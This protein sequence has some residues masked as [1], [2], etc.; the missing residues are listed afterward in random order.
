LADT[1]EQLQEQTRRDTARHEAWRGEIRLAASRVTGAEERLQANRRNLEALTEE[2]DRLD[3]RQPPE[4]PPGT[5]DDHEAQIGAAREQLA[6]LEAELGASAATAAA[7]AR[8]LER[9]QEQE[10]RHADSEAR[11]SERRAALEQQLATTRKRLAQLNGSTA[12]QAPAAGEEPA[13]FEK[14]LQE[15]QERHEALLNRINAAQQEHA[16]AAADLRSSHETAR[17]LQAAAEARSGYAQGPRLALTSGLPGIIGPVADLL[18]VPERYRQAAAAALGARA[19]NIVVETA[20]DGQALITWIRKK[21]AFITV[22]P[23]DLTG[24][25]RSQVP[26]RFRSRPGVIGPVTEQL[27]FAD[28][29]APLFR[30]LLGGTLLLEN[31]DAAVSLAREEPS[32]PR[33]VTLAGEVLDPGGAMSGGR[34][35]T[36][37]ALLGQAQEL[38]QLQE[39]RAEA[40]QRAEQTK[41]QLLDLQQQARD[42]RQLPLRLEEQLAA[43]RA[44]AARRSEQEAVRN[45]LQQELAS[46]ERALSEQLAALASQEPPSAPDE[47]ELAE[48]AQAHAEAAARS[49]HLRE[50]RHAGAAR[51]QELQ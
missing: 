8:K 4:Q 20:E 48:A 21:N 17:R 7:H 11:R 49:E 28:R 26:D 45:H 29:F 39:R 24:R 50:Q 25:R 13:Y 33:L 18:S 27:T 9:L 15:A 14:Q 46:Q 40:A 16:D 47:A 41:E 23:L 42:S 12:G 36:G 30:Q 37:A 32:R 6:A 44:E 35:H 43:A 5:A 19:E 22:L 31:L 3:N 34:R 10:R 38:E 51:L 2:Q 1:V